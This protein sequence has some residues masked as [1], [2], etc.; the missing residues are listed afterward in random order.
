MAQG[1]FTA[2]PSALQAQSEGALDLQVYCQA[3]AVDVVEALGVMAGSAGHPG[4]ASALNDA[5]GHSDKTFSGMI[6]AYG[7]AS[8]SLAASGQGYAS[9]DQKNA[10]AARGVGDQYLPFINGIG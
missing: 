10:A 8:Q 4:L 9:A 5:A 1:G 7:H 3:V 2:K 6:A